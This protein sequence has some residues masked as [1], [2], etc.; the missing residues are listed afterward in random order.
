VLFRRFNI[1]SFH[2]FVTA[3]VDA[4]NQNPPLVMDVARL[5]LFNGVDLRDMDKDDEHKSYRNYL[6][7]CMFHLRRKLSLLKLV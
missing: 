7:R 1:S 6:A 4:D 5:L 2:A 3:N